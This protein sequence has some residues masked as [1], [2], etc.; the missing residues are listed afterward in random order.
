MVAEGL[1]PNRIMGTTAISAIYFPKRTAAST[2]CLSWILTSQRC[3]SLSSPVSPSHGVSPI[4]N[5]PKCS[6][7]RH[8]M[9]RPW[10]PSA[11]SRIMLL[12]NRLS[13][14]T[15]RPMIASALK[16]SNGVS[17]ITDRESL[18]FLLGSTRS[19]ANRTSPGMSMS[20]TST[21]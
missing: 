8:T 7:L 11:R 17:L 15:S 20:R 6:R 16:S 14:L 21:R 3:M 2:E 5:M 10:L 19:T 1:S 13:S 18:R 9:A 12:S 4:T